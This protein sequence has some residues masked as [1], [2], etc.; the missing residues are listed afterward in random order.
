MMVVV[1][2]GLD[3]LCFAFSMHP[4]EYGACIRIKSLGLKYINSDAIGI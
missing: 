3:T 2:S 4:R 1:V